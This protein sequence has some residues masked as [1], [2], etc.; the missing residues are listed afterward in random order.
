ME[1]K[2][3]I[4]FASNI[5]TMEIIEPTDWISSCFVPT[6]AGLKSEEI[7]TKRF[8]LFGPKEI[9]RKKVNIGNGVL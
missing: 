7:I 4:F 2:R 5:Y 9:A 6:P 1:L 3:I 8:N